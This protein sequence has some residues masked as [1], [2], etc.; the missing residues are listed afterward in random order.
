MTDIIDEPINGYEIN[1]L[2]LSRTD[3]RGVIQ[4]GNAIFQRLSG[5]DWP[6][7]IGAPHRVIRHPDMPKA[8]FSLLWKTIQKNVP[9]G[10]YVKNRAKDGRYY[11]VFAV[12]APIE[13]GYLS[14][15]LKPS[16]TYFETVRGL[17]AQML[18]AEKSGASIE[19][20][21]ELVHQAVQSLGFRDYVAFMGFVLGAELVS[22]ADHLGR[23]PD[24]SVDAFETMGNLLVS[25]SEEVQTVETLFEGI[26]T[27]PKNL[28]I[29]G[30][31]LTTGREAMQVI[32]QNYELLSHEI[33]SS[34]LKLSERLQALLE[35]AFWGRMGYC[36]SLL[37]D[38]A[39]E[40][41]RTQ[42]GHVGTRGHG[43]ELRRLEFAL[44][45]FKTAAQ[46][47]C[48]QIQHEVDQ[49][50]VLTSRLRQMLSGLV[51]TR[52]VCRIEAASTN[53]DTK[54]IDEIS[55]RLTHFQ[56]ELGLALDRIGSACGGLSQRI[57][58]AGKP[59]GNAA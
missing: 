57:P 15:R 29:L 24:P 9:F 31:R 23:V 55:N 5:F 41:Y 22:R 46:E 28:N 59:I 51:V 26:S 38:E 11:W 45:S 36:A 14:V 37:Y 20:C 35:K 25:V 34:I 17:Y 56:D 3:T 44:A 39:I 16:T 2:F 58:Q 48:A 52:V 50:G 12:I 27:S 13:G 40:A 53:D 7:L 32:A 6:D 19:E 4:A 33:L 54:S 21:E 8:A 10:A 47:G 18:E 1:D 49:F 30:S 42:E 43:E